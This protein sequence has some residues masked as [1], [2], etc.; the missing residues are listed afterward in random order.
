MREFRIH[1]RAN[2]FLKLGALL[3]VVM[4]LGA[5]VLNSSQPA[6]AQEVNLLVNPSFEGP[7]S[8]YVPPGGHPD[9]PSGVCGTAQTAAGWMPWWWTVAGRDNVIYAN[10]EYKPAEAA[11]FA[12]RVRSG[13]RAQQYFNFGRTNTAGVWQQVTVPANARLRFSVWGMAWST[14]IAWDG[15]YSDVP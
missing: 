12:G 11:D 3:L 1:S 15:P 10:P 13:T 4:G 7:Y 5:L 2:A 8:A 14:G 6:Q 9:C